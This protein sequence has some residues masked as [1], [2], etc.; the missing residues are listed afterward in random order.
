[1]DTLSLTTS[2]K[3]ICIH[4]NEI[5]EKLNTLDG[6]LG[7]GD[8]GVT[9]VNGFKN[10]KDISDELEGLDWDK[11]LMK[12]AQAFTKVSGS[13]FGTLVAIGLMAASRELKGKKQISPL[14]ISLAL[15]SAVSSMSERGK[16]KL[17]DKTVLDM[18][19]GLAKN[20]EKEKDYN[21]L[22]ERIKKASEDILAE[23]R[24]K[25]CNI[26]RA[27]IFAEKSIGIDD[28]GMAAIKYILD[29]LD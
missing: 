19:I 5:G 15:E 12:C 14:D 23:F 4:I 10:L 2:I 20:L 27:R 1:M 28:P 21:H 3:K 25:K 22:I 11:A 29:C 26:G 24:H 7:D 6:K 17:N 8:L 9:L 18:L 13:S 16:A